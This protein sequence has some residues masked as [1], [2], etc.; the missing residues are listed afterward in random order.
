MQLGRAAGDVE[1]TSSEVL[2]SRQDLEHGRP[3]HALATRRGALDVAVPAGEVALRSNVHLHVSMAPE[4]STAPCRRTV[5]AKL[6][7]VVVVNA[8]APRGG[9]AAVSDMFYLPPGTIPPMV[10]PFDPTASV[11]LCLVSVSRRW[12]PSSSCS[13]RASPATRRPS[14]SSRTC[15]GV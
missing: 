2:G 15:A 1:L 14:S 10:M 4:R 5:S 11:P 3:I 8:L 7:V 13:S 6:S 12:T 9:S